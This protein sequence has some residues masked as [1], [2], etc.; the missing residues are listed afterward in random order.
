[1]RVRE[2][3]V[4]AGGI[5]VL[6]QPELYLAEPLT[7]PFV[8]SP[9]CHNAIRDTGRHRDGR[10]LDRRARRA[11]AVVDLGEELQIPD[12]GGP[13]DGDLGVGVHREGD[14]AVDVT[15]CQTG[16][17][18]R[19]QDGLGGEPKLAAAGVLREV[20]GADADDRRLAGQFT[21]HQNPRWSTSRSR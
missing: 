4:H 10:L 20:G 1:M 19:V 3:V 7:R 18:E 9:V 14:H 2:R 21:G 17:V 12:A 6:H 5:G 15:G 13:R 11:A 16:V 8:E